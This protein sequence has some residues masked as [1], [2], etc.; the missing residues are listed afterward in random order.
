MSFH[1][2]SFSHG[3]RGVGPT[4]P[5]RASAITE[6]GSALK[7]NCST[8]FRVL[9]EGANFSLPCRARAPAVIPICPVGRKIEIGS[10][11][12]L[13]DKRDV[14][15]PALASPPLRRSGDPALSEPPRK[16]L[17]GLLSDAGAID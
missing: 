14:A 12:Q 2:P 1:A 13:S 11:M 10:V 5:S 3:R 17:A 16:G 15:L 8:R 6:E 7:C 9:R 4:K